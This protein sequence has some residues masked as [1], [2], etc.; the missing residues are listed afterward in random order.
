VLAYAADFSAETA[1]HA[2]ATLARESARVHRKRLCLP[3][4]FV[5]GL[6]EWKEMLS[7]A[8]RGT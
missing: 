7:R 3:D 6:P 5:A 1:G 8:V 4:G 2:V